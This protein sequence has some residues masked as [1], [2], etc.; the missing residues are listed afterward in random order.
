MGAPPLTTH[1]RAWL[2][3]L[4]LPLGGG[5][6]ACVTG[7]RSQATAGPWVEPAAVRGAAAGALVAA[8][9]AIVADRL[10]PASSTLVLVLVDAPDAAAGAFAAEL[11]AGL[12]RAGF[13]LTEPASAPPAAHRLRYR[14][15][16]LGDA[17]LLRVQLDQVEAARLFRPNAAG[18][19][20]AASPL[21][22]RETA[23]L[24]GTAR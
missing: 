6:I 15:T 13:A 8:L 4:L 11:T 16:P 9:T 12:R 23:A 5:A 7:R 3:A 21:T 10:P 14:V 18:E 20:V 24:A 17:V 2:A 19:L 22:V 1:R